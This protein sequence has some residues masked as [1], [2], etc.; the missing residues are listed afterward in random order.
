MIGALAEV[1][2]EHAL[3]AVVE[4]PVVALR[5]RV[6]VVVV[7]V[8]HS[9]ARILGLEP[10]AADV[11]V[12]VENRERHARLL[13]PVRGE[14]AR[15]AGAD[16]DHADVDAWRQR[17]GLPRRRPTVLALVG[18]L[19]LEQR[20]VVGHAFTT[21]R[22]LRHP[23]QRLVR[24]R[25]R[26]HAAA[27]A[28]AQP[29]RSA[30]AQRISA[31][32]SSVKPLNGRLSINGSGR[33]SSRSS[34]MSPVRYA[35]AGSSGASS[36][37][38]SAV[39]NLRI[40]LGD[41]R[42][43]ADERAGRRRGVDG[44]HRPASVFRD[45]LGRLLVHEAEHVAGD[46]AHL[47]LLGAFGDAVAAVVAVDVLERLVPRVAEA[48]VHLHGPVGGLAAQPVGPVVAHADLVAL[49]ERAVRVH[50]PRR[51]VDQRAQHLALRLQ[52]DQRELDGLVGG[53]RLAERLA[54]LGV[55]HRLRRCRTA[56]RR[57]T[58]RP[59]GCGSR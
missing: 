15:H 18:Q 51:L 56:P 7:R 57:A 22:V 6:A 44:G 36:A 23:Q 54:L 41:R 24:R 13:Q 39:G 30:R 40:G 11:V 33:R 25:W 43:A 35:R 50:R 8:V 4:R 55:L 58:T 26:G 19:L 17:V 42:D 31:C 46:A 48:A 28:I 14:D 45:A 47:D 9:T 12:L 29:A 1:V 27:V 3:R 49:A 52:L 32:C 20:Q 38:S 21:D 34:D 37:A 53:Q 59:G 10:G 2:V 16:D 5:E